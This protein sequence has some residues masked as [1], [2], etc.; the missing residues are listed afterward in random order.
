MDIIKV[1]NQLTQDEGFK[2]MPYEDEYGYLTIGYGTKLPLSEDEAKMILESR[3]KKHLDELQL[4]KPFIV[5]LPE[6]VQEVLANMVYQLGVGGLIG[7]HNMWIAIENNDWNG[8]IKE[9]LDSKWAKK[10]APER[11]QR[12]VAKIKQNLINKKDI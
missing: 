4:Y 9:M 2:G 1:E 3:L 11:A 12:L 6:V 7:F 5:K 8:M 10:D